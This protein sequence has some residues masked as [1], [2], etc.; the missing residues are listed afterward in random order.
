MTLMH[1]HILDTTLAVCPLQDLKLHRKNPMSCKRSGSIYAL[2][3][4]VL[5]V[6]LFILTGCSSYPEK[7]IYHLEPKSKIGVVVDIS[8]TAKVSYFRSCIMCDLKSLDHE[9]DWNL[10]EKMVGFLTHELEAKAG[11]SLV[12][13]SREKINIENIANAIQLV[14]NKLVTSAER[15]E[16]ILRL[17]EKYDVKA[18]IIIREYE[19]H[20]GVACTSGGNCKTFYNNGYGLVWEEGEFV[21][22]IRGAVGLRTDIILPQP[23]SNLALTKDYFRINEYPLLNLPGFEKPESYTT[24]TADNWQDIQNAMESHLNRLA[25]DLSV[26]LESR[27]LERTTGR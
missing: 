12:D 26:I 25:H 7:P 3:L 2:K 9:V 8:D 21:D 4:S 11:Y 24:L 14:D 23:F 20:V 19:R 5:F 27:P 18:F 16:E 17:G 1:E 22:K 13:L 15:R 6:L 10:K